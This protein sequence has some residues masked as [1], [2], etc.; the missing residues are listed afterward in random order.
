MIHELSK[1]F[2]KAFKNY[3]ALKCRHFQWTFFSRSEL[4]QIKTFLAHCSPLNHSEHNLH[5]SQNRLCQTQFSFSFS[6]VYCSL[7]TKNR[8]LFGINLLFP[9]I[10]TINIHFDVFRL[11]CLHFKIVAGWSIDIF[12]VSI[13]SKMLSLKL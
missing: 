13:R 9:K 10:K 1:T 6:H 3:S 8:F 12:T 4:T 5:T 2:S 7:M 11:A